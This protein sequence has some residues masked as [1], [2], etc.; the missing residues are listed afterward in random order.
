LKFDILLI[1]IAAFLVAPGEA[2]ASDWR[3]QEVVVRS[4]AAR[5][6]IMRILE[7]DNLDVERL[8]AAEVAAQMQEIT[9]GAAPADFWKAYQEHVRAW[10]A[11][12]HAKARARDAD[13]L[14]V[15]SLDGGA[16]ATAR[17]RINSTFD[18]VE[19]IA[20]RYGAWPPRVPTRL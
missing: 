11:Y 8:P 6:A 13:P 3:S 19:T 14:D 4:S 20:K 1:A 12:A 18:A 2:T 16:I 9:R 7:A 5:P 10:A 15:D 17:R